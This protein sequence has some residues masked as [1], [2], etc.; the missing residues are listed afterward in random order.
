MVLWNE[1]QQFSLDFSG[2]PNGAIYVS[3]DIHGVGLPWTF[4]EGAPRWGIVWSTASAFFGM[5]P[6]EMGLPN[7][8]GHYD[9]RVGLKMVYAHGT[10]GTPRWGIGHLDVY[11]IEENRV[12]CLE[13]EEYDPLL[14]VCRSLPTPP[15][16]V[17]PEVTP[18]GEIPSPGEQP[19]VTGR[20]GLPKPP[21]NPLDIGGWMKYLGDMIDYGT[22]YL[23]YL[24]TIFLAWLWVSFWSTILSSWKTELRKIRDWFISFIKFWDDPREWFI[25]W[26]TAWFKAGSPSAHET[27][28]ENL[29]LSVKSG[30]QKAMM[31]GSSE[32]SILAP[33]I[34]AIRP[35][36][37]QVQ[38]LIDTPT[39]QQQMPGRAELLYAQIADIL[40]KS[41]ATAITT[42]INTLGQIETVSSATDRIL[43]MTGWSGISMDLRAKLYSQNVGRHWERYLNKQFLS[44]LPQSQEIIRARRL[45]LIE[46][47]PFVDLIAQSAGID[48]TW[49]QIL[50]DSS[51]DPPTLD[52]FLTYNIRHPSD[53]WT[54]EKFSAVANIDVKRY[55]DI[56]L[57]RQWRD[58][59]IREARYMYEEGAIDEKDVAEIVRLNRFR[60]V[61]LPG[62]SKSHAEIMTGYLTGF[63]IRSWSRQELLAMRTSF[64]KGLASESDL[65]TSASKL[66][67]N[68]DAVESYITA[69]KE[70][71][72]VEDEVFKVLPLATLEKIVE[73][74]S[75]TPEFMDSQID[76][77]D[78]KDD[79]KV[80]LKDYLRKKIEAWQI[81]NAPTTETV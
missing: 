46:Q 59:S 53:A 63:Q 77:M 31:T 19:P 2:M 17:P 10:E 7:V 65:R 72:K 33:L 4:I 1:V 45:E 47:T 50:Y 15:G 38:T 29:A 49:A 3:L 71:K 69:S 55:K 9:F 51:L 68:P 37:D 44:G 6:Q 34:D 79:V 62:Q 80:I 13:G 16:E 41:N 76:L 26:I 57:E 23:E 39:T 70:R 66:M 20:P 61:P 67:S 48:S 58:P 14:K 75:G 81:K 64:I 27:L 11:P 43:A 74:G 24:I 40:A 12:T 42:E 35:I 56:F 25:L 8:E 32:A 5:T 28:N 22:K 73:L 78:Y 60:T 54:W 18:P 21:T 30:Q 52:D 36:G